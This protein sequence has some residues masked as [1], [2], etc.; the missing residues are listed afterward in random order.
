MKSLIASASRMGIVA[1]LFIDV[2]SIP[3]L[4]RPEIKK[5]KSLQGKNTEAKENM[6][7]RHYMWVSQCPLGSTRTQSLIDKTY[8]R[9]FATLIF[10]AQNLNISHLV[11]QDVIILALF[12]FVWSA[13]LTVGISCIS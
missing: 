8:S 5:L 2:M 9:Q 6:D 3:R 13:A 7:D 11:P 12:V 1:P 10:S 4:V